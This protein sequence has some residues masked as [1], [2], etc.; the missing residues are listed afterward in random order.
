[1]FAAAI[2]A[3]CAATAFAPKLVLKLLVKVGVITRPAADRNFGIPTTR[4]TSTN[5]AR[6]KVLAQ[7]TRRIVD[8][9]GDPFV[10]EQSMRYHET[11]TLPRDVELFPDF[12]GPR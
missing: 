8:F 5:A 1:M 10:F 7:K 11:T 12:I 2:Q 6:L 9:I 4:T 3:F